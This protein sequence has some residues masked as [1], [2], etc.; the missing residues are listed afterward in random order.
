[1]FKETV[2][3][4]W[5]NTFAI[6]SIIWMLFEM[7]LGFTRKTYVGSVKLR[8]LREI[9]NNYLSKQFIIDVVCVAVLLFD[10]IV[11]VE[12]ERL[13]GMLFLLKISDALDKLT[14]LEIRFVDTTYKE[15]W[16]ELIKIFMTNFLFAHVLA[17]VLIMISWIDEK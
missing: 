3:D 6:V 14:K 10:I 7:F 1:M 12:F 17:I 5:I 8:K 16:W 13:V 4:Q 11:D 9:S 2:K 15:H